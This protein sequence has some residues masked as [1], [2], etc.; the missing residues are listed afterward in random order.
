M[1]QDIFGYSIVFNKVDP[2]KFVNLIPMAEIY[3]VL[4]SVNAFNFGIF[5][6]EIQLF[7]QILKFIYNFTMQFNKN[8]R[9]KEL[10]ASATGP[11]KAITKHYHALGTR[12]GQPAALQWTVCH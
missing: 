8:I 2:T 6:L 1:W 11:N 9:T 10:L 3:S 12:A 7:F 4:L 5:T